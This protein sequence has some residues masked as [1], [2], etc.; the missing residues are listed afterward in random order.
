MYHLWYGM[1]TNVV[2]WRRVFFFKMLL[3]LHK[4]R[5]SDVDADVPAS[6]REQKK[7]M[8][9]KRFFFQQILKTFLCSLFNYFRISY[10]I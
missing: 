3:I 10:N 2:V 6:E 9:K 4:T 5:T 8:L 7:T 1:D